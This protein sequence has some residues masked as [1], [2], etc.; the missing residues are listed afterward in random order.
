MLT[1]SRLFR[2]LAADVQQGRISPDEYRM[3]VAEIAENNRRW[4]ASPAVGLPG[5]ADAPPPEA[6]VNALN[7]LADAM[8]R[9]ALVGQV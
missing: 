4:S 8:E 2:L 1:K 6:V 7:A 9:Y 3:A 5:P